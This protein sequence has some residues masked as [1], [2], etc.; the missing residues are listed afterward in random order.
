MKLYNPEIIEIITADAFVTNG[1]SDLQVVLGDGSLGLYDP[2]AITSTGLEAIDEG[3]GVGWRLVDRDPTYYGNIGIGAIDFG[4]N[5]IINSTLGALGQN[6]FV[7]GLNNAATGIRA[8]A[9]GS[10]MILPGNGAF[11]V[12]DNNNNDSELGTHLGIALQSQGSIGVTV[13]GTANEEFS[14]PDTANDP[15][16]P[17]FIIGNGTIT[18]TDKWE[19]DVRSNAL[20]VLKSGEITAPSMTTTIIDAETSGKV[21]LTR[22]YGAANYGASGLE[23]LDEG[24]GVGWRIIGRDS[25]NYGNI[26]SNAIDFS[27]ASSPSGTL[28]ATESSAFAQGLDVTSSGWGSFVQ[29]YDCIASDQLSFSQGYS[30]TNHGFQSFASGY[31]LDFD[32]TVAYSVMFGSENTA[33]GYN[34]VTTGYDNQNL[35]HSSG[36]N[37]SAVFGSHNFSLLSLGG[38]MAGTGLHGDSASTAIFGKANKTYTGS[39]GL[40][41]QAID[42]ILIVGNG[43]IS[44]SGVASVRSDAFRILTNGTITGDSLTTSL[45]D[46]EPTGK[47]LT[48][49]EWV[50][51][52]IAGGGPEVDKHFEYD[53][54]I[55]SALWTITHNLG[56]FPSTTIVTTSGDEVEGAVKHIN[57]TQLTITYSSSFAGKAYLN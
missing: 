47:V 55:P 18:K 43:T 46:A 31:L 6:S 3:N 37:S 51:D 15:T 1:G 53:Q 41:N 13:I 12:G 25:A 2:N 40:P 22:E 16:H 48:T 30:V 10:N 34:T 14:L 19:A 7:H 8:I 50:E 29:G 49:R 28:G 24:N 9:L 52:T 27:G 5:S 17:L 39:N 36:T 57:N 45:I 54:G 4:V 42:P 56:K 44:N 11:G 26:G 35:G 32:G 20:Q 21:L 33:R 23:S 38:I